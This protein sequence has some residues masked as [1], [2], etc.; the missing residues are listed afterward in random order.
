MMELMV[1]EGGVMVDLLVMWW[2]DFEGG[3]LGGIWAWSRLVVGCDVE[4]VSF[5]LVD[6]FFVFVVFFLCFL[7]DYVVVW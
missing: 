6:V 3:W 5:G 1:F 7:L 4:C 2:G